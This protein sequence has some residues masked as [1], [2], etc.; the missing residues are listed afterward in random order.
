MQHVKNFYYS[1]ILGLELE[2]PSDQVQQM[3][4]KYLEGFQWVMNYYF[5][6]VSDWHWY[7]PF[8]YAP[9]I[10]D[11]VNIQMPDVIFEA[12]PP[13]W[14][15]E[16][17]LGVIP[18][19]SKNILPSAYAELMEDPDLVNFFPE[20]PGIEYDPMCAKIG[21]ES[22]KIKVPF[23]PYEI[24]QSKTRNFTEQFENNQVISDLQVQHNPREPVLFVHS[25]IPSIFPDFNC[26]V[27][28]N[29]LVYTNEARFLPILTP[30]TSERLAGFSSLHSV[31]FKHD[32][33]AVGVSKFQ[34]SSSRESLILEFTQGTL[35]FKEACDQL[36]SKSFFFEYP[37][38]EYGLVMGLSSETEVYPKLTAKDLEYYEMT[39]DQYLQ[40]VR[41]TLESQLLFAQGIQ[42]RPALGI[43]V[44][45]YP[46]SQIKKTLKGKYTAEWSNSE[47]FAPIEL[48][49]YT[50][51][52][53]HPR[54]LAS[55]N[56]IQEEFPV[57]SRVLLLKKEKQGHL[58]LVTGYSGPNV[59]VRVF[60]K[61]KPIASH[62][63]KL[64]SFNEEKY[65]SVKEVSH[66]V[67]KPIGLINK[68]MSSIKLKLKSP[69]KTKILEIGL[70]LK[71]DR[72]YVSALRWARWGGYWK[73]SDDWEYSAQALHIL[74]SYIETFP[75]LWSKLESCWT[76]NK[77]NF[78]I[79]DLFM[80]AKPPA[81]EAERVA[82]WVCKQ[83]SHKEPWS[84]LYSEYLCENVVE[85]L[86]KLALSSKNELA[87]EIETVNPSQIY[88]PSLPWCPVFSD[89]IL[90]FKLGHRVMNLN[91]YYN[92]F[93]P[94]AAEGTVIALLD[95]LHAEVIWDDFTVK[96]RRIVVPT[97]N[98]FNLSTSFIVLKRGHIEKMPFFRANTYTDSSFRPDTFKNKA[99]ESPEQIL[100]RAMSELRVVDLKL[101]PN[102]NEFILPDNESGFEPPSGLEFPIPFFK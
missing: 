16:Q 41:S 45:Y 76:R 27:S 83:P 9:M 81:R 20:K 24:I 91:P 19:G 29:E 56:S 42:I 28:I 85:N 34:G 31:P 12:R 86:T 26:R 11:F 79:E 89:K 58:G 22:L 82:L 77:R 63:M 67:H 84:S 64:T 25:L 23:V 100:T 14:A 92:H 21:W 49:T 39:E 47:N 97:Q 53:G 43:V 73:S 72:D 87:D 74:Q 3:A 69:G 4:V 5:Q 7:Y 37:N 48:L 6:G 61:P 33:R 36:Y 57:N 80:Y 35:S 66:R 60:K 70:N 78:L 1:F 65:Y 71:H 96:N 51:L 15:L 102:A 2:N 94:F 59:Q 98:L 10:S 62:L 8:N 99:E 13:F 32:L 50:R 93:I 46:L 68:I 90:D 38:A 54:D 52:P 44:H 55:P 17:L 75:A 30:G 95:S 101:N 40:S 88:I 18:P